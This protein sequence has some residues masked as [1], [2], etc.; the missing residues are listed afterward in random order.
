[1]TDKLPTL[2][3]VATP[4]GTLADLSQRA[5]DILSQVDFIAC[6]DTRRTK[7][8]FLALDLRHGSLVSLHEHNERG[9]SE[10]LVQRL[11]DS[12]NCKAALVSDAGTPAI[13]DPGALFVNACH[14]AN[15]KVETVPGPS[16]LVAGIAASGFLR[17][18]IV[19]SG[20]LSRSTSE[21]TQEFRRWSV[22]APCIAVC[23]ES[24]NRV[25]ATLKTAGESFPP[26]VM[27]CVSR[28]I[29]KKFEQHIRGNIADVVEQISK[30]EHFRGECVICFDLPEHLQSQQ[31]V[32]RVSLEAAIVQIVEQLEND[33]DLR[34]KE[35]TR[36]WAAEHN[37]N[38]KDLYNAVI[39]SRKK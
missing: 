19:F 25:L 1:M 36:K 16:S 39:E 38:A 30:A 2:Y 18:R 32:V 28:E 3:I 23:F 21:Q 33:P 35:L 27:V 5:R 10:S 12:P 13:S 22:M 31:S 9:K 14:D 4:I 34:V 17:P 6:E 37:L 7:E 15:I 29:S 20:F 11:K 26:D 8:L 24:P